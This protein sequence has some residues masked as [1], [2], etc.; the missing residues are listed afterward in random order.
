MKFAFIHAEKAGVSGDGPL[1]R[2]L[3]VSRAGFYAWRSRPES[4]RAREDRRLTVLVRASFTSESRRTYG[5]PRVH[6]DL[7]PRTST[8]AASA[9]SG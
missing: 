2:A 8:S 6:E 5:S 4:Q 9:S 7:A 3:G 1:R